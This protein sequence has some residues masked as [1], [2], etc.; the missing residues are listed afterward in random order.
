[1]SST[2]RSDDK[3]SRRSFVKSTVWVVPAIVTLRTRPAFAQLGS[4][5]RSDGNTGGGDTKHKK[6]SGK[7]HRPTQ[8][9]LEKYLDKYRDKVDDKNLEK[10]F[11]KI[12]DEYLD[13]IRDKDLD[14]LRGKGVDTYL[15]RF[16]TWLKRRGQ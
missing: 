4:Q 6:P 10:Y 5:P 14:K 9:E 8:K 3:Q 11:E 12:P 1:M 15:E 7:T 2:R 16:R 13:K